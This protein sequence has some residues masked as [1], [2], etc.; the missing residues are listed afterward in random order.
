MT[1]ILLQRPL[2]LLQKRQQLLYAGFKLG[3]VVFGVDGV[4]NYSVTTPSADVSV[5]VS[6]LPVLGTLNVEEMA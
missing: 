1:N 3:S 4:E 2:A 5:A 6:E